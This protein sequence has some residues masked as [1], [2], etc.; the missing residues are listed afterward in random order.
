LPPSRRRARARPFCDIVLTV[1]SPSGWAGRRGDLRRQFERSRLL[2]PRGACAALFFVVGTRSDGSSPPP[3]PPPDAALGDVLL[4]DC[5]DQD[6]PDGRAEPLRDSSTSCKVA[7]ALVHAVARWRFHFLARVGDDAFFRFD[8]FLRRVAPRHLLAGEEL[9]MGS[10]LLENE[11][12]PARAAA[13][14]GPPGF[15][16]PRSLPYPGGMGYVFSYNVSAALA[17]AHARVGL[18]DAYAEDV[19][20][21]LWLAA[22]GR[23][24]L[25]RVHS[26]CFH[27]SAEWTADAASPA[28]RSQHNLPAACTPSSLLVHYMNFPVRLWDRIGED[29]VLRDCGDNEPAPYCWLPPFSLMNNGKAWPGGP[30]VKDFE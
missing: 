5:A 17:A 12:A 26:P 7:A 29:G 28:G 4:V 10:W 22:L 11:H 21:G 30:I 6:G 13:L 8:L 16:A 18:A 2:L 1:P 24:S 14:G 19:M 20:V 9:A 15:P 23:R 27:N 3:P 25:R